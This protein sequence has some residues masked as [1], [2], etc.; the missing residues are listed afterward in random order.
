MQI[1][2]GIVGEII[3]LLRTAGAA[4]VVVGQVED[5]LSSVQAPD[6]RRRGVHPAR[7]AR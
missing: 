7:D 4:H 1:L 6:R 3:V 5:W 2:L